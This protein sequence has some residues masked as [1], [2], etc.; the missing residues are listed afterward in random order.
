MEVVFDFDGTI[1]DT[2][3]QS[4][5]MVREIWPEIGEKDITMY[6]EKGAMAVIKEQG[7]SMV[8]VVKLIQMIQ[9]TQTK[10]IGQAKPFGGIKELIGEL[11]KKGIKVGVLSSNTRENVEKWLGTWKIKVDWVKTERTIFGKDKAIRKIKK[12][13]IVYIGDEVRDVEACRKVG[14]KVVAVSWGFNDK[15]ALQ[16]AGADQVVDKVEELRKL[17]LSLSQ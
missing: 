17:L 9:K 10:I 12:E 5:A 7:L 14:V 11:R 4:V 13:D 15:K 6:R 3:G 16:N 2:F 8:K 1:A